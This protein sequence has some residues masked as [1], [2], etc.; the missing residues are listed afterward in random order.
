MTEIFSKERDLGKEVE[1]EKEKTKTHV[2]NNRSYPID[3]LHDRKHVNILSIYQLI[4]F[5][6]S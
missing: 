2:N 5:W 6:I 1:K 4:L 3:T